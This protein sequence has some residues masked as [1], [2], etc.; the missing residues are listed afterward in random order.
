MKVDTQ[1]LIGKIYEKGFNRSSF[2]D[3]L[4]ISRETL[5]KYIRNPQSMPYNV[6][7]QTI[8]ILKLSSDEA[9]DIFF[10]L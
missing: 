10:A 9:K 4:N 8:G 7:E 1:R 6:I 2:A 3:E 5:R